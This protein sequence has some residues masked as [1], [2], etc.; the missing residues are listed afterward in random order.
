MIELIDEIIGLIEEHVVPTH[1][2]RKVYWGDPILI[3][4]AYMPCIAVDGEKTETQTSDN[5]HDMESHTMTVTVILNAKDFIGINDDTR[6]G[7]KELIGV[8]GGKN[9]DGTRVNTSIGYVVNELLVQGDRV[10]RV[11][12]VSVDY[13]FRNRGENDTLEAILS[14]RADTKPFYRT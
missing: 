7:K 2:I 5:M 1:G 8:L 14:F 3:P 4:S 12:N 11:G 13:G 6:N 9:A 10:F